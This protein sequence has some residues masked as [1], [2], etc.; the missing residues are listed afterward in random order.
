VTLL[1]GGGTGQCHQISQGGGRGSAKMSRDIFSRNIRLR[2]G[3][4]DCLKHVFLKIL[5]VTS[6]MGGGLQSN[7]TK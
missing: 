3:I 5:N 7:V 6:H 1:G 2:F 4:L